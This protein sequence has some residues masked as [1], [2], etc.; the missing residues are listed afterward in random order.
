MHSVHQELASG[1]FLLNQDTANILAPY[2]RALNNPGSLPKIQPHDST[3]TAIAIESTKKIHTANIS[4]I[5]TNF[6]EIVEPSIFIL[7]IVGPILKYNNWWN[8]GILDMAK[9][10]KMADEHP[11]IFAHVIR[12][13]SGGGN[14]YAAEYMISQIKSLKK[15]VFAFADGLLASAAYMMA[16]PCI[17]IRASLPSTHIGSIGTYLVFYDDTKWL[18]KMGMVEIE[19]YARKSKDKNAEWR[20]AKEGNFEKMQNLVD[21]YNEFFLKAIAENRKEKL[22]TPEDSWGTGKMFFAEQ[23]ITEGLIDDQGSFDSYL[24]EIFTEFKPN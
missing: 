12:I 22:Q 4:N 16:T 10:L 1:V 7:N 9:W 24:Q 8:Y 14:A 6:E 17:H 3:G 19:I 5:Y 2:I 23:A 20:D 18:E 13:D 15:P 21:Q 11:K